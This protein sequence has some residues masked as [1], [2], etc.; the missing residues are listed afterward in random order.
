MFARLHSYSNIQ[1]DPALDKLI[2]TIDESSWLSFLFFAVVSPSYPLYQTV[3]SVSSESSLDEWFQ[4]FFLLLSFIEAMQFGLFVHEFYLDHGEY[5]KYPK[6][7]LLNAVI[8]VSKKFF[9]R[10]AI[11]SLLSAFS[12]RV[13][14]WFTPMPL[15]F[16]VSN[17]LIFALPAW[18]AWQAYRSIKRARKYWDVLR[19]GTTKEQLEK[20]IK[21]IQRLRAEIARLEMII[22]RLQSEISDLKVQIEKKKREIHDLNESIQSLKSS[23]GTL[24]KELE[25]HPPDSAKFKELQMEILSKKKE[26][27]TFKT[28]LQDQKQQLEKVEEAVRALE[29]QKQTLSDQV[30]EQGKGMLQTSVFHELMDILKTKTI[31]IDKLEFTKELGAGGMGAVYLAQMYG[32]NVAVKMSKDATSE[33]QARRELMME[34]NIIL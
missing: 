33:V 17:A 18:Y 11:V 22:S 31:H 24:R 1:I 28:S 10:P 19:N 14:W 15:T 16:L 25:H 6:F 29:I 8:S 7:S 23:I 20:K 2:D 13:L 5:G 3:S 4:T 34:V 12:Y 30:K 27:A 26:L 32:M 21:E 9:V